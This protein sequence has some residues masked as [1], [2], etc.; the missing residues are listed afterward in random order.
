MKISVK[1]SSVCVFGLLWVKVN[2]KRSPDRN[3]CSFTA[4]ALVALAQ[5]IISRI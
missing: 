3:L 2:L 1:S 4:L 5:Q